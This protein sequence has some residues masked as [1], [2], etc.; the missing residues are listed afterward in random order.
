MR[1]Q[2]KDN[3]RLKF[4]FVRIYEADAVAVE[5]LLLSC[6]VHNSSALITII[7]LQ[8]DE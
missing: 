8:S 1:E 3:H 7:K 4:Q 5:L 6:G 2:I